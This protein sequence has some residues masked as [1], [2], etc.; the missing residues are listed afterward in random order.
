MR[1][2][3]IDFDIIMSPS[4]DFYNHMI[5]FN[6]WE[7]LTKIPFMN[8]LNIDTV[9]YHRLTEWIISMLDK[10]PQDKIFFIRNHD[11]VINILKEYDEQYSVINIDHH[12]DLGYMSLQD[13]TDPYEQDL[14]C[15]NWVLDLI[16]NKVLD[17][18]I[19]LHNSNFETPNHVDFPYQHQC[20]QNYDIDNLQPDILII[21]LSGEWIPPY[22]LPLFQIWIDL[23]NHKFNQNLTI[24]KMSQL[25]S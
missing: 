17:S 13:Q 9:H 5:P 24:E 12:H 6:K 11:E 8:L 7:D 21:C 3:T 14:G 25:N 19:W 22:W 4:I 2:T 20:F 18:Y 10:L 23:Y 15:A 16:K 1:V